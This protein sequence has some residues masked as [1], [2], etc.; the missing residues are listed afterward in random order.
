MMNF[1]QKVSILMIGMLISLT[2][3]SNSGSGEEPVNPIVPVPTASDMVIYEANPKMFATTNSI[4]AITDRLDKLKDL[5]V[6]VLW[7]MP[8][9]E[10]GVLKSVG[11]PYCT[12]D[13]KSV[14]PEYGTLEDV[15]ALVAKAHNMNILVMFDWV[16]NHTS[17]DNSWI[18]D[19]KDWY[20][21]DASENIISPPNQNWNDVAQLN[22]TNA[23]MRAAMIDAMKYWVSTANIDGYRCDY[24]DGVPDSFWAEAITAVKAV[25]KDFIFLAEG[26]RTTLYTNGFDMLYAWNYNTRLQEVFAGS[27]TLANLYK[28]FNEETS[29]LNSSQSRLRYSVNHDLASEWSPIQKYGG[30]QGALAAFVLASMIDGIPLI[31]SSQEIGYSKAV[32]FFNYNVMDW[33]SN[34]TYLEQYK[35]IIA[36]YKASADVRGGKF[37]SYQTG[38]VATFYRKANNNG[39]LV[40]VNTSNETV[41]AKVPITYAGTQMHNLITNEEITTPVAFTLE[42]Y[43]YQILK[44]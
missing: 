17:W 40:M 22:F 8:I 13:Y 28:C 31:Y 29:I 15:K 16:A 12:K 25:K 20:G 4:N 36:A 26:S 7:L 21:Q 27:N 33:N 37:T 44:R 41:T 30:E 6:N 14:N 1:I 24:A 23:N 42:P 5:G 18:K 34:P 38:K 19:H 32:S 39:L 35:A 3:C 10:Q 2:G 9:Y 11:S 43:Q